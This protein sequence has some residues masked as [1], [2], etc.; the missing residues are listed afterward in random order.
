MLPS[1]L[2]TFF[3]VLR[4]PATD[5]D[6]SPGFYNASSLE[7]YS[8]SLARAARE[9]FTIEIKSDIKFHQCRGTLKIKK[10][11]SLANAEAPG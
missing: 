9:L 11:E 7:T 5:A 8:Q 4:K 1:N 2:K 10:Q 3:Q 6:E